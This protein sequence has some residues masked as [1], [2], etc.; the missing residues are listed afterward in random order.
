MLLS[1]F[2]ID[3]LDRRTETAVRPLLGCQTSGAGP[4]QGLATAA[5]GFP[6]QAS[7]DP[8]PSLPL[9]TTL[10]DS[11]ARGHTGLSGKRMACWRVAFDEA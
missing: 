2:Q 8:I 10:P 6:A 9:G 1:C 7:S 11:I 4:C 3:V 5:P